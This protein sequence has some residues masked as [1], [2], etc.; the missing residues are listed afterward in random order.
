M[1]TASELPIQTNASAL[2]MANTIFGEGV[3]VVSASYTGDNRSSGIYTD[4]DSE[5]PGVTP[6]DSGVMFSTG[7]LRDFTNRRG[8]P[9]TSTSTSSDT[10]GE[11]GNAGFNALAGSQTYDASYLDIDVIPTG[12]TISLQFVFASEEY[13]EYVGSVFNDAVGIWV[14]GVEATM[15][16]GDGT[17]SV[18]NINGTSNQ[19]LYVDN[20]NDAYNTEMDGFTVTM[21]VKMAV[22]PNVV[23]SI[24]IGIA[25][26]GD[27]SY[28]STLLV[29]AKSGQAAVTA[30]D[31]T[32]SIEPG[33]SRVVDVLAND[34]GPGQSTLTITHV[35]GVAV[36]AGSTVTLST[37]QSVTLNA[38][39]TFTIDADNDIESVNFSYTIAA[40]NGQGGGSSDTAF[41]TINSIPCFVAGTRIATPS[42]NVA[43][44]NLRP[45]DLVETHDNGA[46]PLRW[47]GRRTVAASGDFAPVR[48]LADTFGTHGQLCLSPLHRILIRDAF[49]ELL[50]GETDVLIAAKD[51]VNDHSVCR[52][53]GGTVEYVHILFD[54]HQ[55]VFSE[56]LATES[57]LPG[58]QAVGGFEQEIV[59]EIV[60]LFPELDPHTGEGYS[61]AVRTMLKRYEARLL[62][63]REAAA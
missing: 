63:A 26:V 13:P 17:G 38:D 50:F 59:R 42:G 15:T 57:F 56:G 19:N 3:T 29:A 37:G 43:V 4:G 39:G 30:N 31:D 45:G 27:T 55:V 41:V 51:L 35:N 11:D 7:R 48:I 12:D 9:N 24:R 28:D 61:P 25:D 36:S 52:V 10:A 1:A 23:N 62:L 47:V 18:S 16:V 58:P 60:T 46:Q 49:A 22:T 8:D 5:A 54:A 32:V 53:E 20:T 34:E 6:A 2:Q 33:G 40:G 14:N 44:Q 21:T